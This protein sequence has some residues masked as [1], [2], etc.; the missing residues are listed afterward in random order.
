MS[1]SRL[2]LRVRRALMLVSTME[3]SRLYWPSAIWPENISG[4]RR[5]FLLPWHGGQ[6]EQFLCILPE[7]QVELALGELDLRAEIFDALDGT[8]GIT[9]AV[10]IISA[11]H[12]MVRT[13]PFKT[14][15][16]GRQVERRR[17]G[18]DMP[19]VG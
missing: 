16:H 9:H 13:D 6:V 4:Q 7:H 12:H 14:A 1:L 17:I 3:A 11:D 2:G 8:L 10:G 5:E 15:F 18:V 19:F